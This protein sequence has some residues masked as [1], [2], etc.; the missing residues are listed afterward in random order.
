M[1]AFENSLLPLV[2]RR[3]TG[4][5]VDPDNEDVVV[6]FEN[7]RLAFL[8][9]Y[10]I[11]PSAEKLENLIGQ[12]VIEVNRDSYSLT[13]RFE[14]GAHLNFY[15]RGSTCPEAFQGSIDYPDGRHE[16]IVES[17]EH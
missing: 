12:R 2:G 11:V 8:C 6:G 3:I 5:H 17:S 15:W 10:E 1:K 16:I 13:I 9:D 4:I 14:F 7:A